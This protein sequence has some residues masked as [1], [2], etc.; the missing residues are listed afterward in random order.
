M[1]ERPGEEKELFGPVPAG[2]Q[3]DMRLFALFEHGCGG[4]VEDETVDAGGKGGQGRV[5]SN[6]VQATADDGLG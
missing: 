2:E 5:R 6:I 1:W 3:R 4:C